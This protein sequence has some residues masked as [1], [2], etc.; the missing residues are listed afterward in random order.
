MNNTP[1]VSIIVPVYN[2]AQ[3]LGK[4]ISSLLRQTYENIEIILVDDGSKDNSLQICK[5]YSQKDERIRVL[6]HEKNLGQEATR[7]D[8][9]AILR[10][11]WVMFLDADD[12]YE[13]FAVEQMVQFAYKNDLELAISPYYSITN[14]IKKL[15]KAELDEGIYSRRAF[16][17]ACL[18]K[19]PWGVIS[20]VGTK[21]YSTEFIKR[22]Q[23]FFD[24]QYKFNEDGAFIIKALTLAERVGYCSKPFYNYLIRTSGS[25]ES[26]HRP[27]QYM[28]LVNRNNF[29]SNYL[30]TSGDYC[31]TQQNHV[32]RM[33]IA[34]VYT[35]LYN[36]VRFGTY[37]SFHDV[38]KQARVTLDCK[39][40]LKT[41]GISM[42]QKLILYSVQHGLGVPLFCLFKLRHFW[43]NSR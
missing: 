33:R 12:E 17:N 28:Y 21:I 13:Q 43:G 35:S 14:G 36:E 39:E 29:I 38:I 15:N 1:L 24:K 40:F 27:G 32:K 2:A 37:G 9:L 23:I 11:Q 22:N 25:A 31:E 20:C 19:I 42:R 16:A 8:G 6:A 34:T 4:S 10:G 7:N 41:S 18:E 3:F 5:E 30:S 26:S